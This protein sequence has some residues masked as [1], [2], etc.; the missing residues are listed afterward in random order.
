MSSNAMTA[1]SPSG[2]LQFRRC[3][4]TQAR[5]SG[6]GTRRSG[7]GG[8]RQGWRGAE[9]RGEIVCLA[10]ALIGRM[11]KHVRDVGFE[12]G[13]SPQLDGGHPQETNR[14]M[15]NLGVVD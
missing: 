9:M 11:A 1:A 15:Y 5:A 14:L 2:N 12:T 10:V 3:G 7:S 4:G 8:L 6:P 13:E